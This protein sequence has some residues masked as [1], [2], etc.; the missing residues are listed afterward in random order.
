MRSAI[1][2]DQTGSPRRARGSWRW[3]NYQSGN[4]TPKRYNDSDKFLLIY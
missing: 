3:L 2:V 1:S 4:L